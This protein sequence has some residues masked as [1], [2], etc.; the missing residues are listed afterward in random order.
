MSLA[1]TTCRVDLPI[2]IQGGDH[3]V[4]GALGVAGQ[5]PKS[6]VDRDVPVIKNV[7]SLA[8]ERVELVN[9]LTWTCPRFLVR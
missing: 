5:D 7:D 3:R 6:D 8:H 1:Q 9:K 2:A 4:G